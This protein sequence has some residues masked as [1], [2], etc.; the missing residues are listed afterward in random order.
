M[1]APR[2]CRYGFATAPGGSDHPRVETNTNSTWTS[3]L[4]TPRERLRQDIR[5]VIHY[6]HREPETV[7]FCRGSVLWVYA[8]RGKQQES[9]RAFDGHLAD[10]RQTMCATGIDEQIEA[11]LSLSPERRSWTPG[12]S[13]PK[14]W[15]QRGCPSPFHEADRHRGV[16]PGLIGCSSRAVDSRTGAYQLGWPGGLASGGKSRPNRVKTYF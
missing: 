15:A 8:G 16:V 4:R 5:T 1:R 7:Q 9:G 11:R 6:R 13:S 12:S 10:H 2:T 14:T 3:S